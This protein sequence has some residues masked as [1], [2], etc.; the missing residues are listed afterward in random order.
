M[1]IVILSG[2]QHNQA[3]LCH[4]L[5]AVAEIAA[6]VVSDNVP[7]KPPAHRARLLANRVAGRLVGRPF[8]A[9]WQELQARY[10][11]R[12]ATFP[13]VEQVP[14]RNVNDPATLAAIERLAPDLVVVSGTNIVG[15]KI[16]EL[17]ARR[18]GVVNMHT[19]ISPYVKGGPNCT[20]WCLAARSFHLIGSTVMWLDAGID[21]GAVIATEQTPLDGRES[22]AD[23]HWKVMEHAHDLYVRSLAAIAAGRDVPRVPQSDVGQGVTWYN[24]QWDALAMARAYLNYRVAYRP[25]AFGEELQR[26][27]AALKLISLP[28]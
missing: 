15:K 27:S 12:Y 20:N 26:R 24:Y 5:A 22:L 17:A 3:A 23:L 13:T 14:V 6:I 2:K 28:E 18:R 11:A 4:K 16:I 8:V 19:G 1:K 25:S 10:H 7:R 9:A 21:T